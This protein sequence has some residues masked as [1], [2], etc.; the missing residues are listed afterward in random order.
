MTEDGSAAVGLV[1]AVNARG[2]YAIFCPIS[3]VLARFGNLQLLNG[4][5]I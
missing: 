4:H 3:A 5:G 2:G 1:F